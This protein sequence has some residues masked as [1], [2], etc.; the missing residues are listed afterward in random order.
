[1]RRIAVLILLSSTVASASGQ[2]QQPRAEA[3]QPVSAVP[4]SL[5]KGLKARSIGP[6][7]M[8]GRISEIAFDPENPWTFY[9]AT[10]H[11]GL[12]KTA[13]NGAS[14]AS[15]TD[16]QNVSSMGAVAVSPS[17]PKV[18]W[19]GSGEANDRNSSG[20]GRGVYRSTD[21]G[22]TWTHA[23]L[24]NS[25]TIAR[26]VVHP[27]DP[28]TAWVAAMGDLWQP[29]AERGCYKTTDGGKT[30]TASLRGQG[31]DANI[32]GCGELA[33]DPQNP[34]IVYATLYARQRTPWSF[35]SGPALT[36]GRDAGGIYRSTDG[37]GT[38]TKLTKG[39]PG[40]TGRIGLSV[41]PKNPQIV[42][43][44]VESSEGGVQSLM[45]VNSEAGGV[46][47]S[48]DGGS[49]WT[50]QT[51]L[52]PR[53]FYF[54]QIRVH[55]TDDKKV[56][57]LGFALLASEDG[58]LTFREDRGKSI[59]PDLHALAFD[60]TNPDRMLLGTDGGVYVTYDAAGNWA[61][62]NTMAIGE[63][64]RINVDDSRPFY[65]ICGGL[66][67]N[68]NW[69]GPS[70]TM[71]KDGIQNADW[72][73]IQ[74]GDGFYCVFDET[75]PSFIYT[76]S[77]SG[78]AHR[79]DLRSGAIEG[80]R[81]EP[82][83][84]QTAFRFHWNSPLIGSRAK[85]GKL[86]LG[87]NR[88][89]A[90]T[91]RGERWEAVSP[92]LSAKDP[93][94]TITTGSGAETYGV[95]FSLADSPAR[96]GTLW[97]GTDDGKVWVGHNGGEQWTDLTANLPAAARN[98]WIARLEP[99]HHDANVAYMAVAAFRSGNYAPLVYRTA[100]Q[101]KTWQS[102]SDDLPK[103]EPVR[104]IKEDPFNAD[105]L[106]AGTEFGLYASLDRGRSWTKFGGL[107]TVPVD[108]II[109]HPRERDLIIAT[110]GRSLFIVD[111]IRPLEELTPAVREKKAHLF[112]IAP[113][114]GHEPYPGWSDWQGSTGTFR[115][116][117]QPVGALINVWVKE[118]TGDGISIAIKNAAGM[119][120]A[121]LTAPGTPG[122][123][124]IV[125]NLKPTGDLLN[126]YGGQGMLFVAPGEYEVTLTYG[127]VKEMQKVQVTIAPGLR[128]R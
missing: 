4:E 116:A 8:G 50:R 60:P 71:T 80:L 59:H 126:Q 29:S 84:G 109:I 14:F 10:A 15:L 44:I 46:F 94:K 63:F 22:G 11:G 30:W 118:F 117:N 35:A 128:T 47:R 54:S 13:D 122:L 73:N 7:I 110:H 33:I 103:D 92:D 34:N 106:F 23:G 101:G 51:P 76:E 112:P 87:G 72:I 9:A 115:G 89:F 5:I 37:G 45:E 114:W 12:M 49:S 25:K 31:A 93:E 39:L 18:I 42:Y 38:W 3:A 43:A 96:P 67:D 113:A 99:S 79:F 98:Q 97:A 53:P 58:G 105:L 102:V 68:L 1:M 65:R 52:N 125:W 20:W 56:Y 111:D 41:F 86:Y 17:N 69:V 91:N 40:K 108:D 120:V 66:Q 16:S 70:N 21:G 78:Y 90:L 26:I 62:L 88:V 64:Y 119:P 85:D 36:G 74:G 124:R 27:K 77:Q 121:N 2:R 100:D 95:V 48:D 24:A 55:P 19:L 83:E 123:S 75:E 104:V 61:H 32:V 28:D 127:A 107:P 81:P 82:A 6:A 57:V